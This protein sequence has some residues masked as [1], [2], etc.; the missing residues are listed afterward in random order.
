MKL[1]F[2][3]NVYF[4]IS[5]VFSLCCIDVL[6]YVSQGGENGGVKYI[7]DGAYWFNII[8]IIKSLMILRECRK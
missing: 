7:P 8:S 1:L 5:S 4:A 6:F 2:L 3:S